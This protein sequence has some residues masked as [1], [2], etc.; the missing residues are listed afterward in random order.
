MTDFFQQHDRLLWSV[1]ARLAR[2]GYVT[3]PDEGRELMRS[4]Y[5]E[6]W[7]NVERDFDKRKASLQT[8]L[9]RAFYLFSRR[10]I[11]QEASWRRRLA[12]VK[13]ALDA[14]PEPEAVA[15]RREELK[16]VRQALESLPE[17]ERSVLVDFLSGRT[18]ERDLAQKHDLTRH[19]LR[20]TLVEALGR[21]ATRLGA[22]TR[23]SIEDQV[24]RHLWYEGR[25]A[26]DTGRLLKLTTEEVQA[27]RNERI[28][29]FLR[30]IRRLSAPSSKDT[31]MNS[32]LTLLKE[33]LLSG[34]EQALAQLRI[35]AEEVREALEENDLELSE[36]EREALNPEWTAKVFEALASED[37]IAKREK[38]ISEAIESLHEEEDAEIGRAF[39]E[40]LVPTLPKDFRN[41]DVWFKGV[42]KVPV[43]H[44]DFLRN[45][46][47]VKSGMPFAEGLVPYGLTP[48]TFFEAAHGIQLLTDRLLQTALGP[49]DALQAQPRLKQ[50]FLWVRS[51]RE[52]GD[53]TQRD[54]RSE[55][56]TRRNF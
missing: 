42:P 21:I 29:R 12:D 40:S 10:R 33:V 41:W 37:D 5:V 46:T 22:F 52:S 11:V 26:R 34:K 27:F 14:S 39:A 25:S 8:Y 24:A 1:L 31:I 32:R 47:V 55:K 17:K 13:S 6:A 7:P 2:G 30:S 48:A 9:A 28:G 43:V 36:S 20:E 53:P 4:F 38:S 45:L 15:E 54:Y 35:E 16:S 50:L 56:R 51:H 49:I 18:R 19:R 23:T 44:Q 3:S